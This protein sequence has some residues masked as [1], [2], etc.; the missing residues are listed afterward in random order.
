MDRDSDQGLC[1]TNC[2]RDSLIESSRVA[3]VYEHLVPHEVQHPT[4]AFLQH[5]TEAVRFTIN[6][7]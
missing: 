4:L 5:G 7:V 6:L 1:C 3:T 2:L